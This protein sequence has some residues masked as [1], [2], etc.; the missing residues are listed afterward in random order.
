MRWPFSKPREAPLPVSG[1]AAGPPGDIDEARARARR[2]LIGAL[3]LL[4]VGVI[5]FPLIFETQP[6]P[7]SSQTP[8]EAP[9]EVV[10]AAPAAAP[11]PPATA[12]SPVA[13]P[14]A[15]EP[16]SAPPLPAETAASVAAAPATPAPAPPAAPA[17]A[18]SAA[19]AVAAPAPA[20][21]RVPAATAAPA[22]SAPKGVVEG[23]PSD[24]SARAGSG[25]FVVQVGAFG[26]VAAM[27][28]VR[29][30]VDKL[31]FKTYT[32]TVETPEGKRTRLRVGPFDARAQAEEAAAKLK[33]A[34][35]AG[36]VL[37]L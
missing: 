33:A 26:T 29:S 9:R 30:K 36:N 17:V 7:L 4:V 13:A 21:A 8:V 2:R 27:R 18:A 5:A 35:F 34:G 1:A 19:P 25:R 12:A 16:A 24:A 14:A 11:P 3:V 6:R 15:S 37:K 10:T 32:Q 23:P 28:E 22:A 20:P 31:G